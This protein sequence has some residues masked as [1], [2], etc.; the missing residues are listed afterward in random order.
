MVTPVRVEGTTMRG[1]E[2]LLMTGVV[3][4]GLAAVV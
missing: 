1:R 4:V 2:W 3:M